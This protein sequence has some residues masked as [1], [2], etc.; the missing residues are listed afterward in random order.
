MYTNYSN[1][2]NKIEELDCVMLEEKYNIVGIIK[3]QLD[4]SYD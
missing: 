3:T 2:A 1:F 4:G